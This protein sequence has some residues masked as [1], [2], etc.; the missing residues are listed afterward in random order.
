MIAQAHWRRG[1]PEGREPVAPAGDVLSLAKTYTAQ[2]QY[3]GKLTS[4]RPARASRA[5]LELIAFRL[6]CTV[7][8]ARK[9]LELGL[10]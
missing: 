5:D 9:A 10:V 4:K 1:G 6:G 8:A 7:D 3:W 2:Q